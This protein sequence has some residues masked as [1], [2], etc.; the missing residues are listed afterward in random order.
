MA[1]LGTLKNAN[2]I[3]EEFAAK[4]TNIDAYTYDPHCVELNYCLTMEQK[5]TVCAQLQRHL[6]NNP[7]NRALLY[8]R[9]H[10]ARQMGEISLYR[11]LLKIAAKKN[12]SMLNWN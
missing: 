10:I 11:S 7:E 5:K 8:K 9:A 12:I 1:N 6:D 3:L 4:Y 2:K